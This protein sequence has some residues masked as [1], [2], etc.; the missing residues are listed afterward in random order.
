M[1]QYFSVF[2][3]IVKYLSSDGIGTSNSLFEDQLGV[4]PETP[5]QEVGVKQEL[6]LDDQF[7]LSAQTNSSVLIGDSNSSN[8]L[9]SDASLNLGNLDA[10]DLLAAT[11]TTKP[12]VVNISHPSTSSQQLQQAALKLQ[13][14]AEMVAQKKLLLQLQQQQQKQAQTQL[15][16]QQLRLILQQ[17]TAQPVKQETPPAPVQVAT[18]VVTPVV[19]TSN[20]NQLNIQQLQQVKTLEGFRVFIGHVYTVDTRLQSHFTAQISKL[21][22]K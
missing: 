21:G 1:E 16:Q 3:D 14:Q 9:L 8:V 12:P 22:L 13:K 10:F 20:T 17:A 7:D 2:A 15:L 6:S 19:Q 18:Q 11:E 5:M 4:Y